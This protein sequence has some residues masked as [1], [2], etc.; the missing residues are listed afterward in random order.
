M[1][2]LFEI[3]LYSVFVAIWWAIKITLP[4]PSTKNHTIA[5][6]IALIPFVVFLWRLIVY[7]AGDYMLVSFFVIVL[8]PLIP[9][10]YIALW[11]AFLL[12]NIMDRST[13]ETSEENNS[14]TTGIAG[15]LIASAV[16]VG[17]FYWSFWLIHGQ[18]PFS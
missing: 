15:G 1:E 14:R 10:A 9:T 4:T 3:I 2:I 17:V 13:R 11:L 7:I 16:S 5:M 8:P 12:V 18:L 6:A